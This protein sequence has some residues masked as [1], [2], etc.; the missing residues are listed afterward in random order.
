MEFSAINGQ[1]YFHRNANNNRLHKHKLVQTLPH[2]IMMRM[3]TCKTSKANFGLTWNYADQLQQVDLGGG[4]IAY[5]VY[6]SNGNRV[7]KI[8]ENGNLVK[9]R[10]YL[11]AYEVYRETQNGNINLE[12]ETI[13]VMDDKQRIALIETR[14][15]GKDNGLPFL[16]R[17]QYSNHLNSM[18]G[19]R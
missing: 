3:A 7:R 14:T 12:R 17:Y 4:G 1:E 15:K 6:D 2:I 19:I 11:N 18:F 10:I 5:Y 9:E 8:I 16:I 13:H